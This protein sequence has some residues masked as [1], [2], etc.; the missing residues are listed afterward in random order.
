MGF[1]IWPEVVV[2]LT[3][4]AVPLTEPDSAQPWPSPD[5][6]RGSSVWVTRS[7]EREVDGHLPGLGVGR[8]EVEV[9]R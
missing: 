9:K 1:G 6:A 7:P 2:S 5:P 8:G 4:S 3:H